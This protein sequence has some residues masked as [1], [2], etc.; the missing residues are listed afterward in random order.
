VKIFYNFDHVGEIRN[1][2]VTT[3]SFDGVHIGHKVILQRLKKLAAETGGETVLIT[4]HP[5]PRKVLYPETAGKGLFL[6]NSQREKISLLQKAGLDNLIIVEFTLEFSR[7]TSVEFVK[8]I[9]LNKLHARIIVIGFNHHFGHNREGDFSE[10]RKLGIT[11][12]FEV[13][14]IPEQDIQNESVSSTKIRKAIQEGSIQKA[15]AY[16]DHQY[17]MMG[18]LSK[19]SPSLEEIG[20]PS[21]TVRI[22]DDCKLVPTNGV[23]AVTV[24][25]DDIF[26]RAM[27][28]IR[29]NEAS[30]IDTLVEVHLLEPYG[31]IEG[32]VGTL[33][34]H[35]R[36][37]EERNL[38]TPE[39]L[40]KQLTIDRNEVDELIF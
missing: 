38:G 19:S 35:K 18:L 13:E 6:I 28:F 25:G 36:I 34:F 14:E 11:S 20:F 16:L 9:L 21:Y 4:F 32:Q 5:H 23:Y 8:T 2:V 29:K 30:P 24:V 1:A 10:L 40:R 39:E 7:I 12:G 3:G 31:S 22:E 15:N 26:S 33:L 17:I 27:C 37:R